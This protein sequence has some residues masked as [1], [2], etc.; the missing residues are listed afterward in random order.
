MIMMALHWE[1]CATHECGTKVALRAKEDEYNSECEDVK[2]IS[3]WFDLCV[4]ERWGRVEWS[5]MR[6]CCTTTKMK[7][8]SF[9]LGFLV[10]RTTHR[11]A[12]RYKPRKI[13][14]HILMI[15]SEVLMDRT[16]WAVHWTTWRIWAYLHGVGIVTMKEWVCIWVQKL[17]AMWFNMQIFKRSGSCK[18]KKH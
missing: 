14:A 11:H 6:C 10:I 7:C 1:W 18:F 12:S 15:K 3:G 8:V 4:W 5:G 2:L 17:Y 13:W 16:L 9:F